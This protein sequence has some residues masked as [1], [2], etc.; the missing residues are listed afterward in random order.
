[1][2]IKGK[3]QAET[4]HAAFVPASVAAAMAAGAAVLLQL[5]ALASAGPAGV[6]EALWVLGW[7][8]AFWSVLSMATAIVLLARPR[9]RP[10]SSTG[11][12]AALVGAAA[13]LLVVSAWLHPFVG[14]GWGIA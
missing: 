3:P 10:A 8:I 9:E 1:M 4:P 7:A 2:L 14:S 5:S 11:A 13:L 12:S 6:T